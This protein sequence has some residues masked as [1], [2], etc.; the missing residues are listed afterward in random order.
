MKIFCAVPAQFHWRLGEAMRILTPELTRVADRGN[1]VGE[2][3]IWSSARNGL[4]W[5]NCEEPPEL[6]FW[7]AS[8]D[9][10]RVW[11]V[12]QRLGGFVLARYGGALLALADGIYAM[13]LG[14]GALTKRVAND[15]THASLHEC[16]CDRTGRLWVG[17][18]DRRVGPDNLHPGGGSFFRMEGNQLIRVM[19]GISCSNGLAFSPDGK[20]LY[21]TDAPTRTIFKWTLDPATGDVSNQREFVRL[22]AGDGFC[23][24]ATVDAE[25]G[26]W[27]AL[28]FGGKIRRYLPDGT[29]DV[30]IRLPFTNPT[31]VAFGGPDHSTLYIT[32]TRMSIGMP[33]SGEHLLGG[34]Y[35]LQ[36]EYRGLPE[37]LFERRA[38]T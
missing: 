25:G 2:T 33:Q 14:D 12:P 4:Y 29:L 30:E 17:A 16:R 7:D 11:P 10:C 9:K 15:M 18:I 26:Y 6:Q 3:P 21:H 5:T 1:Q 36:T 13:D 23:D 8:S 24:G 22:E 37:P 35:S 20:T 38:P 19:T 34:L 28:V 31:N 32:T 27:A